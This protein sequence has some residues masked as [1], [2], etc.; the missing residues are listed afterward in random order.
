MWSFIALLGV[1]GCSDAEDTDAPPMSL[2]TLTETTPTTTPTMVSCQQSLTIDW[3]SEAGGAPLSDGDAV[4]MAHG[5]QGGWHITVSAG[6]LGA[7]D[8]YVLG[9]VA[10]E[11]ISTGEQ[12]AG[13]DNTFWLPL[14]NWEGQT[15]AGTMTGMLAYLD[16]P[17]DIDQVR[18]CTLGGE[19]LRLHLSV[20][21]PDGIM[22]DETEVIVVAH[23]DP[24]DDCT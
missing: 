21:G 14:F 13:D 10:A 24:G 18:I 19:Q 20:E 9:H 7:T 2:S 15:C 6:I 11:V 4:T 5:P 16:D 23:N 1:I 22:V 17:P 3:I 12:L 8:N